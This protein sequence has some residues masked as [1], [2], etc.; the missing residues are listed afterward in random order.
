MIAS[1]LLS[2]GAMVAVLV[3]QTAGLPPALDR[4]VVGREAHSS[5]PATTASFPPSMM[6]RSGWST[7]ET[8]PIAVRR[9]YALAD[10][11]W[12]D[13]SAQALRRV[14]A[15]LTGR[16]RA[17]TLF[18]LGLVE[19]SSALS[20]DYLSAAAD[21]DPQLRAAA[22]LAAG[23]ALMVA[24]YPSAARGWLGASR[25]LKQGA[26]SERAA[27]LIGAALLQEGE[28]IPARTA[29]SDY[30][31]EYLSG[32][33]QPAARIGIAVANE[34]LGRRREAAEIYRAILAQHRGYE[35]E[36]WVMN[37]LAELLDTESPDEAARLRARLA[38]EYPGIPGGGSARPAETASTVGTAATR[39]SLPAYTPRPLDPLA[40]PSPS[41]GAAGGPSPGSSSPSSP[42]ASSRPAPTSP[43]AE[44]W[45]LQVGAFQDPA[46]ADQQRRRFVARGWTATI[47]RRGELHIVYVGNFASKA[48]AEASRAEVARIAQLEVFSVRR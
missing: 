36:P 18:D 11:G 1:S 19:T 20:V 46:R 21:S 7:D 27:F 9:A 16:E 23:E 15:G 26:A 28:P 48:A 2:A 14:L 42:P 38:E 5:A 45:S 30:L 41:T 35:D 39:A 31:V 10:S 40:R 37:R 32:T 17:R 47:A 44:V 22:W 4:A 13:A 33:W 3:A 43:S 8:R 6:P 29:F 24:G 12:L 34:Q 25:G